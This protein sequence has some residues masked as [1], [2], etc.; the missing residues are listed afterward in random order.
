MP[1]PRVSSRTRLDLPARLEQ[2]HVHPGF[3]ASLLV[4]RRH[5]VAVLSN[6]PPERCHML[7]K[8]VL[9][10]NG[11]E[12]LPMGK[13][14]RPT[15]PL[16]E[17][18]RL[19]N[20]HCAWAERQ[21]SIAP[22]TRSRTTYLQRMGNRSNPTACQGANFPYP[23]FR[24]VGRSG[25]ATKAGQGWTGKEQGGGLSRKVAGRRQRNGDLPRRR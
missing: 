11:V 8:S 18:E 24:R 17:D 14:P 15:T 20:G 13:L 9:R 22:C 7:S 5:L 10:S 4:G 23:N 6:Q 19:H 21:H 25:S 12:D 3:H 2:R 16:S 1:A